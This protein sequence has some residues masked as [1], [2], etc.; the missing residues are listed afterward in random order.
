MENRTVFKDFLLLF[1]GFPALAVLVF[2]VTR[3]HQEASFFLE[4][5]QPGAKVTWAQYLSARKLKSETADLKINW[6]GQT[7]TAPYTIEGQ[8]SPA[9]VS[10]GE[11]INLKT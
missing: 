4:L 9:I 5:R 6:D 8:L 10:E 3:T 1:F 7:Q 2:L 11:K